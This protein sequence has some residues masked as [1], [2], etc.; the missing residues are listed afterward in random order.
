MVRIQ[1][2]K[3]NGLEMGHESG[4]PF[5]VHKHRNGRSNDENDRHQPLLHPI[6]VGLSKKGQKGSND[7]SRI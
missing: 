4:R 1:C 7:I 2:M 5:E 3:W 6:S